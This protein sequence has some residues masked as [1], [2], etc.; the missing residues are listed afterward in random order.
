MRRQNLPYPVVRAV[1]KYGLRP[2]LGGPLSV[3]AQR[4]YLDRMS[5]AIPLPS[6]ITAEQ[7]TLG[8]RPALRITAADTDTSRAIVHLHGGAYTVGSPVS[9]QGFGAN[10]ARLTG[11]PV[12]LP[13]YRLAPEDPYPAALDDAVAAA[14]EV[15][16]DH[17]SYSLGGDS[18]GGGLALAT[19]H[20]LIDESGP[21]PA[22]LGLIAPWVDLTDDLPDRRSDI[23]V[24]RKW[25]LSSAEAYV[26]D[27]DP[28]EPGISPIYADKSKLPPT[29][30]QVGRREVLHS[31]VLRWVELARGDG[32]DVRLVEFDRLW[33]VAHLHA[34]FFAEA[35]GALAEY[36][37][38]L[39]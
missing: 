36:A 37:A 11:H 27:R 30:V 4:R 28:G 23:V 8:G 6:D 38:F 1:V 31:Q 5:G 29:L 7:I 25:G 34:D 35:Y 17:G 9:Y 13:D 10:L 24:R 16:S 39:R 19:T 12:Y 3:T 18:A 2:G 33:H 20:R 26:G 32:A 21:V 14:R 22:R 15:A